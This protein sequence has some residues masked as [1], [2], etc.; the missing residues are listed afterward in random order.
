[1]YVL[2]VRE[3]GVECPLEGS[4][5]T[6]GWAFIPEILKVL[7]HAQLNMGGSVVTTKRQ[8]IEGTLMESKELY[9]TRYPASSAGT[10]I[11]RDS[12]VAT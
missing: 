5:Q 12:G 3:L 2:K 9:Q 4:V 11:T 7:V 6:V 10:V 8:H 1:M